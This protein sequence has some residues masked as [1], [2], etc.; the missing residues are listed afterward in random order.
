MSLRELAARGLL[1]ALGS[2]AGAGMAVCSGSATNRGST[3]VRCLPEEPDAGTGLRVRA[4]RPRS[5]GVARYAST[6]RASGVPTSR[7][8][9][10]ATNR[11]HWGLD[12]RGVR[13]RRGRSASLP[14]GRVDA[15]ARPPGG[16]PW[17]WRSRLQHPA[18]R[19]SVGEEGPPFL[20][21]P[22]C[23]PCAS[24]M[25]RLTLTRG[26][27]GRR[28]HGRARVP[29]VRGPA[30]CRSPARNGF[31]STSPLRLRDGRYDVFCGAWA[32]GRS[33]LPPLGQVERLYLASP[34]GERFRGLLAR[35]A[36][37]FNRR[38]PAARS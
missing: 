22:S 28:G 13:R 38:G 33:L 35:M 16:S 5:V 14:H 36:A 31:A 15:R 4:G 24:T 25:P 18:D 3:K 2:L 12:R 32:S 19:A 30:V 37:S 11:G 26:R 23:M 20:R 27:S 9:S 10:M 17:P 34:E 7:R 21:P 29:S 6:P 8:S 1:L